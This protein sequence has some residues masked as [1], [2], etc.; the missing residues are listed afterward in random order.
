MLDEVIAFLLSLGI[1]GSLVAWGF[2][3]GVWHRQNEEVKPSASTQTL[4]PDYAFLARDI[5]R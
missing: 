4:H 5:D 2:V 3:C 1:L